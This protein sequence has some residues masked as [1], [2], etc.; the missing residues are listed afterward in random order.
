MAVN[1]HNFGLESDALGQ[2]KLRAA[3]G[4]AGNFA[5]NGALFTAY[6]SSLI[7]GIVGIAV[8]GTLGDPSISPERQKELEFGMDIGLFKNRVSLELSYYIKSVDD[9]ILQANNEPSS[10]F[11]NIWANAGNLEN[12]GIEAALN[13][14]VFQ[15]DNF[16]WDTGIIFFKNKSEITQL[17][18]EAFDT[19]G[20][21]TGLGT[22]RIEEGKS[23][24]Q[25]VGNDENGDVVVLGN[26]EPDFQMTFTNNFKYKNFDLAFLW[27]W[28]KGGDN[29]NLSN[30]LFDFGQTS[31]DYDDLTLDPA[32]ETP[33]GDFRIGAFRAGNAAPFVED[34]GYLRLREVGLFYTLPSKILDTAFKGF[35]SNIKVGLSG[36]NLINVFD[37]NSYDPEVSNF[38]SNGLST[39]VEVTPFPTSKRFLFHVSVGF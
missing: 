19:G 22:F 28:K 15:S 20:F 5:P 33:N 4:E 9:L 3:Y 6:A 2:L 12:K 31:G 37:Y 26:A 34:A 35:V 7:D 1:I 16:S 14:S 8:P 39:G 24:T 11:A 32:G 23:V 30:L 27:H 18:V 38:G 29:I 17:D 10:G 25:I 36:N 21:G 13:A